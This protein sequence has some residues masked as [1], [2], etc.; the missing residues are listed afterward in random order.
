MDEHE[1]VDG[2]TGRTT[3]PMQE[4]TTSQ[5]GIGIA[6]LIVGL[7]LSFGLALGLVGI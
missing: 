7:V 4:F 3:S 1:D 5:V 2:D 6:V